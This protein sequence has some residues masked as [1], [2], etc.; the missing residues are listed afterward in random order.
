VPIKLKGLMGKEAV[1]KSANQHDLLNLSLLY[2][3]VCSLPNVTVVDGGG[4]D[5][6]Q[7]LLLHL[8]APHQQDH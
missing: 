5:L 3:G 1:L 2:A 4:E 7:D 8:P 6:V